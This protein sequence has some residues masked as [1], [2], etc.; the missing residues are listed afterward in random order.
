MPPCETNPMVVCN[1]WPFSISPRQTNPMAISEGWV[2]K[3]GEIAPE[4]A[5][6]NEANTSS[7]VLGSEIE[8]YA[9]RRPFPERSQS[10]FGGPFPRRLE[11]GRASYRDRSL[12]HAA[13]RG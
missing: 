4:S 6:P 9:G 1:D 5:S 10:G 12:D 13:S 7:D 2:K 8:R 3:A 11:S